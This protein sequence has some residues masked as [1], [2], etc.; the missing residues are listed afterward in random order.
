M[1]IGHAPTQA[2]VYT[3]KVLFEAE[4]ADKG[5]KTLLPFC[6][7]YLPRSKPP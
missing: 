7:A 2:L 1:E 4:Y 5:N 3:F 6:V